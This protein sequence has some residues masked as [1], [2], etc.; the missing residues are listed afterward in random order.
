MSRHERRLQQQVLGRVAGD[1]Q[2]G[3]G[4]QVATIG[5]GR[6]HGSDD[7]LDVAVEVAD[8]QVELSQG[9]AQAGHGPSVGPSRTHPPTLALCNELAHGP[10]SKERSSGVPP[11][12]G[13]ARRSTTS[14]SAT[15]HSR[16]GSRPCRDWVIASSP[17]SRR[18][19]RSTRLLSSQPSAL[20]VLA[21]LDARP[22]LDAATVDRLADWKRLE[23][24][25]IAARDLTGVDQLPRVAAALAEL[26]ADVIESACLL[27]GVEGLAVIGMGKLGGR[28]LNYSSDVDLMFV[29]DGPAGELEAAAR[30]V[31]EIT[32]HCFRV[33]ANLRPEGRDGRLVRTVESY[34]AYWDRWAEPWEFQALLKAAPVAGDRSVGVRFAETAQ[35]WLWS[36]PFSADDLRSLRIMKQRTEE[37]VSRHGLDEREIKLGPGGIR[38]IEFAVQLLQLVHGHADP[39]LRSPTTLDALD[40]MSR[41]GYVDNDDADRAGPRLPSSCA[42]SSTASSSSTSN[43]STPCP[44]TRSPSTTS[45]GCSATATRR[46]VTRPSGSRRDLRHQQLAVRAI[47]ERLYFRPLLEAFASTDG[48]LSPEAAVAR[49][50]AFGFTDAR[51]TQAAV[52]ELTRGLNRTSRLMQQLLPLMLDWLSTSSDPDLGLLQLRN[53]LSAK[54][55]QGTA[56]RGVPRIARGGP[57]AVPDPRH[58]AACSATPGP[59]PRPRRPPAARRA[60]R[61]PPTR[62]ARGQRHQRGRLALRDRPNVGTR[63]AGGTS[64]TGSGSRRATCSGW[65][66]SRTVGRDLTALGEAVLEVALAT[67][68]PQVPLRRASPWADSAGPS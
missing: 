38:D 51:R 23:F 25:R 55:R 19:D 43:R 63:C 40:E 30:Q 57:P 1:R 65:P 48:A 22:P 26:A 46:T 12:R 20:D 21:D 18:A 7:A 6:L 32:R 64:A 2:L 68:E 42:R 56:G 67:L 44:T 54:P 29:G 47:H 45:L 34:E 39:E 10:T 62:R 27:S 36:H 5:L 35:R 60:P 4:D 17:C 41:A 24:L 66:T 61:D 9:E 14:V 13:S 58:A 53:L 50:Q 3:E 33:D 16:I 59:Q 15:R 31:M 49:L 28:E 52:R 37:I 11:R 8:D